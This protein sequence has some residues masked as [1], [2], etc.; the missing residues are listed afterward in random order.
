MSKR[1]SRY[2]RTAAMQAA[3]IAALIAKDAMFNSVYEKQKNKGKKHI[4]AVSHVANKMLH[5]IF[6]VLKNRKPYELRIVH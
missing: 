1:G 6:S 2:L 5:V 3:E 4:V